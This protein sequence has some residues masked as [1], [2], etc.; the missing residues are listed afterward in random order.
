MLLN[1]KV[2]QGC[3]FSLVFFCLAAMVQPA[4]AQEKKQIEIVRAGMLEGVKRNGVEVRRLENDVVFR[5][6]ETYMYC[7]S[8][9]FYE[10]EN[11]I[12][13]YGTIRIEGPRAKLYGDY[14]HYNGDEEKADITGKIV[15]MTD[16]KMELTTDALQYNLKEDIGS[17]FTGGKVIDKDNVLTSKKGYYFANDRMVFFKD[18]VVL[19][20]P[21]FR[22]SSDTLKYHTPTEMAYFFGPCNIYSSAKDSG[23]IYCENGWYNTKTEKAWFGKNAFIQSREN[24]LVGD[25]I[26]YDKLAGMGKAW[27]HVSVTDTTQKMIISGDY[28][29]L[30]EKKGTSFVTGGSVL[31]KIFETDSLFLHADTLYAEQDTVKKTK[32]YFA[33][34]HVRIYKPDLQGQCDSLIYHTADST[35][36]F[37]TVPVLWNGPNQLT[38]EKIALILKGNAIHRMEL[39]NNAFITGK[40]DSVRYNQVKGRDMTGYFTDNKLTTIYVK[41]NG[42]S[43]YYLRNKKKQLTGVNQAD[44]SDMRIE[45]KDNKVFR[46]ALQNKPDATLFPVKQADPAAMI[47]KDFAW[48][49][50]WQPMTKEDIFI[51]PG[52]TDIEK[53]R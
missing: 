17:Y 8:A 42:Q 33:Y 25:S 21:K 36:W 41:G 9:L 15:R 45:I 22:L 13:A 39:Y 37:Y 24:K 52:I 51:W 6:G 49:G 11:T 50:S 12:D 14:L 1:K 40:E 26:V 44:C 16:G 23:H 30:D 4:Q 27:H 2:K 19:V 32:T 28:A 43:V 48:H 46:I 7:D 5:Q 53:G 35:I 29:F 31:T 10:A 3:Y 18:D 34:H 20:N 47:L 38:A